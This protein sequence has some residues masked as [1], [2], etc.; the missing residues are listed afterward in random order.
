MRKRE[1]EREREP[2]EMRRR[3]TEI[4]TDIERPRKDILKEKSDL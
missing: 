1:K 2:G 3:E 4:N